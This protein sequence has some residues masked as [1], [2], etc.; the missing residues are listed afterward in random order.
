MFLA[1]KFT[2]SLVFQ[3][4]DVTGTM[5]T[6][7]LAKKAANNFVNGCWLDVPPS[8]IVNLLFRGRLYL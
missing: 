6:H 3:N 5:V 7:C 4:G 8:C 2:F 1:L